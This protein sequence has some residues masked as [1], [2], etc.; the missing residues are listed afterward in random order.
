VI[1][2][3]L[4]NVDVIFGPAYK[5]VPL[6]V[7]TVT[8]LF[9]DHKKNVG[10][11]FNRKESKDHGDGGSLVGTKLSAGMKVVIVED[12]ITAGTTVREVVPLI[13]SFGDIS[14]LGIVIS[15]DR[16]ERGTGALSAVAEAEKD[17]GVKVFPIVNIHQ[18]VEYLSSANSSGFVLTSDLKGRIASYLEEYGAKQ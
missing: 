4:G 5:G 7:S 15:V 9:Q 11:S 17:Q 16:A 1:A 8:A 14:I 13:H 18:I 2:S 12:V 10:F 6:S 3:G